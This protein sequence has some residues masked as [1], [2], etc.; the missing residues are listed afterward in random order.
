MTSTLSW[1]DYSEHDRRRA[2]EVVRQFQ[3]NGTVDELGVG[4]IR[5]AL[6]DR[7]FPGISTIQSRARYFLFIP[8]MYLELERRRIPSSRI[9]EDARHAEVALINVLAE[10]DDARG[11][12]GIDARERLKNLP[13]RLYW[14]GLRTWG[15]R[16][17]P[18]SQRAYHQSLDTFYSLPAVVQR[19]DDGDM[20]GVRAARNWHAGIPRP[21]DSFPREASM[22]LT[23][24]EGRYLAERVAMSRP[25]TL[26][27]WLVTQGRPDPDATFP[28]QHRQFDELPSQNQAELRHAQAFSELMHGSALLYN[29]MLAE[30]SGDE[31]WLAH[32]GEW[33]DEWSAAITGRLPEL[34]QWDRVA[35]WELVSEVSRR[36]PAL[37]RNF[38]DAWLDLVLAP[39]GLSVSGSAAARELVTNRERFLK[40]DLARLT[41]P[42]ALERWGGAS[43]VGQMDYR[44][45]PVARDT[46]EDIQAAL[47]REAE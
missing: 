17:F 10:S 6:S 12:V 38:V 19:T 35:F 14:A 36:V 30:K 18:D 3:E 33:L 1:L 28:W 26:L 7:L 47:G 29:Y 20:L 42:R 24:D 9:A 11:T 5:D 15:I 16:E 37:T 23:P 31:Q 39:G 22:S 13:S 2:I 46:I 21:P 4:T 41:N 8:W 27:A 34:L 44:W 32:Y 45:I 43:G 40:R 25:G